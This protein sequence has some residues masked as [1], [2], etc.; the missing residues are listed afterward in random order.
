MSVDNKLHT[1]N[2]F[3]ALSLAFE[4]KAH[5][6]AQVCAV[7]DAKVCVAELRGTD[8]ECFG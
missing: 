6:T 8:R 2:R 7:G 1:N 3:D 4:Y 5:H